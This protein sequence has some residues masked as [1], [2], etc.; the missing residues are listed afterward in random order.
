[1]G[2]EFSL[3]GDVQSPKHLDDDL[4]PA[5]RIRWSVPGFGHGNECVRI[6]QS[7]HQ[8]NHGEP[9]AVVSD[10]HTGERDLRDRDYVERHGNQWFD[11]LELVF[12]L[13]GYVQ[14]DKYTTDCVDTARRILRV[15]PDYGNGN[16]RLRGW[17]GHAVY[18][19]WVMFR[20]H[21]RNPGR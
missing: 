11:F 3:W 19:V 18:I 15:M 7:R 1:L 4:D 9:E 14:S 6:E 8:V 20:L 12:I 21:C 5:A 17:C 10:D 16:Q 13:W 2:L